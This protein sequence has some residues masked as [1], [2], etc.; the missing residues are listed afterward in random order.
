MIQDPGF[1][2]R[3][4]VD[5]AI[6]ALSPAVNDPTTAVQVIDRT[7]DLLATVGQRPDPSGWYVDHEGVARLHCREPSLGRLVDLSF[8]EIIRYGADS[9]Q[10]VRRLRAAFDVLSGVVAPEVVG[11]LDE[12]R[13]LLDQTRRELMPSA[14]EPFSEQPD[15]HGLG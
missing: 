9:P 4:L 10:V 8:I 1:V 11:R 12:L 3:Q 15:R 7:V 2:F 13:R 6:R 14:F 5:V